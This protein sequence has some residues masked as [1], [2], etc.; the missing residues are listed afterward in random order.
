M[1]IL[2]LNYTEFERF[3]FVLFRVGAMIIFVPILGSR[4]I[5][6]AVKIGLMLFL[7]IAI[8]P[9]VLIFFARLIKSVS[10]GSVPSK[11]KY[12]VLGST[13]EIIISASIC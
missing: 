5:P 6:G 10:R 3:L 2:N 12:V 7:S 1:D 9:L 13:L 11:L 4:Q 8:F